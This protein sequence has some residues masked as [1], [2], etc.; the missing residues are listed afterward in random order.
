MQPDMYSSLDTSTRKSQ[1][2][3]ELEKWKEGLGA[4][5]FRKIFRVFKAL[6]KNQD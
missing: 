6:S 2:Q 5:L 3:I 1:G 4:E